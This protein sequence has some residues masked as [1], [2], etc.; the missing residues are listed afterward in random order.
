MTA[1]VDF[2]YS[3][4]DCI[5]HRERNMQTAPSRPASAKASV[6]PARIWGRHRVRP[7]Q[8]LRAVRRLIANPE[9]TGEVFRVIEAL[10]G[11][12]ITRAVKRMQ[13]SAAGRELLAA[14]PDINQR[15]SDRATLRNLPDGSVGRAYLAL[16]E[17]QGISV[18]G[19]VAA[20]EEVPRGVGFTEDERWLANRLRDI[21]D[22]QHVLTGYGPDPLG[23]LCLLSFMTTQTWNRGISFIV[24]MGRRTY[25]KRAP[26][27]DIDA[28]VEEGA[29]LARAAQWLPALALEDYLAEPLEDVRRRLGLMTPG[30]YQQARTTLSD[31]VAGS[32]AVP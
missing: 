24:F 31:P 22:L 13:E 11:D 1:S 29:E 12:S 15:L 27:I 21:H 28:L 30:K 18:Q 14:K 5:R 7:L 9:A 2:G 4:A 17:R 10:K 32:A 26:G 23:E 19:L 3:A 20:S 8:A 16:M 6:G 25:R